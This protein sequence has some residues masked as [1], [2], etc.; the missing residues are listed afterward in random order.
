MTRFALHPNPNMGI[1]LETST[2]LLDNGADVQWA[3]ELTDDERSVAY[4]LWR[5]SQQ[6][7]N[8]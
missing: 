3:F 2:S 1:Y 5:D 6:V 7:S 4:R 8:E